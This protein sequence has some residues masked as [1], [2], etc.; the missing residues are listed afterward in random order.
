MYLCQDANFRNR[1]VAIKSLHDADLARDLVEVFAHTP[2]PRL[3]S[4]PPS[5]G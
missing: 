3:E 4:T 2:S 1:E 5:S